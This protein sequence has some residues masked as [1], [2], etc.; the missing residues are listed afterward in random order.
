MYGTT[1][2]MKATETPAYA[3]SP[4]DRNLVWTCAIGPYRCEGYAAS[5]AACAMRTGIKRC[6]RFSLAS[7]GS[8]ARALRR[9]RAHRALAGLSRDVSSTLPLGDGAANVGPYPHMEAPNQP[10]VGLL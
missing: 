1:G 4:Y 5:F 2:G 7:T 8:A 10:R 9:P 3:W 6:D